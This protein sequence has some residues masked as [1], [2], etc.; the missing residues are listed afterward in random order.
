MP[1]TTK[2]ID[3]FKKRCEIYNYR[4]EQILPHD[5]Y[6][7]NLGHPEVDALKKSR[8][9]F[10]EE[11]ERCSLLGLDRLN[12]HPGSHLKKIDIDLSL[13][14]VSESINIAL[15]QTKGITLII[16]NTAG[17]GSNLGWSFEEI[18][19]IIDSV[20]DQ[21]RVGVCLDT[22]HAFA[23]GYDLRTID[24][25]HETFKKFDQIIGFNYLKGM[26]LNDS[27]GEL[28][29]RKDRHHSLGEGEIGWSVFEY[30]M[31]DSRFDGIPLILETVDS[32]IWP[33]EIQ[34]LKSMVAISN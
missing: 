4:A 29:S 10:I 12:F 17:Q 24:R 28:G 14:R 5:S 13:K 26:H 16:E 8:D 11:I 20:E 7:I 1:L 19:T 25:C 33:Q 2:S 18:A 31:S 21:Q 30:I 22:C 3:L 6:L 32:S 27:K 34:T 23:A 15:D 9:A